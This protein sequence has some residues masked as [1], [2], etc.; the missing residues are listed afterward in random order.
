VTHRPLVRLRATRDFERD[1]VRYRE[2]EALLLEQRIAELLIAC[3]DCEADG[4][5]AVPW[6][7]GVPALLRKAYSAE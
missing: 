2:G 5:I 6:P 7:R 4:T 3:G 1:G